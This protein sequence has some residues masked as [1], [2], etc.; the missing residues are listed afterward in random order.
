MRRSV[1]FLLVSVLTLM[2]CSPAMAAGIVLPGRDLPSPGRDLII[3]NPDLKTDLLKVA[4]K[5]IPVTFSAIANRYTGVDPATT[6]DMNGDLV[7]DLKVSSTEVIGQNGA[8]LQLVDPPA[9]NLDNVHLLPGAGYADKAPLQ[10]SRVYVAQLPGGTYAKFM[11]L[12]ATPKVTL[13]FMY[14]TQT[15]SVLT[16][17]GANSQAVLTWDAL[18][19]AALGY[20]IYRYEVND[21]A[22]SITQLNDFTVQATTFTNETAANR[23]YLYVVQAI[24]EG[25]SPGSLTTVAAVFVTHRARTLVVGLNAGSAKLDAGSVTVAAP[26]VIK[27]GLMMVPASLFQHAGVTVSFDASTG[28]LTMS[29]RLEAVTY[30]MVMTIDSPDYTWNGTAYKTDV[31]PYKSGAEVMVPLRVV[32]PVLGFGVTFNSSTRAATIGW[33]E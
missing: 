30:T 16:V 19:D 12:Q 26:P 23:Y 29:R 21:N 4:V 13:W 25:G 14:G 3:T 22:Y 9:L 15:N 5:D 33:Y 17:D 6:F 8:K 20:N 18:P 28:R 11:V 31:P 2:L 24:K 27:R 10:L 32:A 7:G 1:A